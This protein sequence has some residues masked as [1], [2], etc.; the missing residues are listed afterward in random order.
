MGTDDL[1]GRD[2]PH[3]PMT[4]H[5]NWNRL[6]LVS[7]SLASVVL[8]GLRCAMDETVSEISLNGPAVQTE[9][10][11]GVLVTSAGRGPQAVFACELQGMPCTS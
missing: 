3:P 6:R 2:R 9:H 10:E 5:K 8:L 4:V 1:E 7:E 11:L